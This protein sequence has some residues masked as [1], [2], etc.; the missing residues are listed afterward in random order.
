MLHV[1]DSFAC[2]THIPPTLYSVSILTGSHA[3]ADNSTPAHL[4]PTWM[5]HGPVIS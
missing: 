3:H 5:D 1:E 4:H 2:V